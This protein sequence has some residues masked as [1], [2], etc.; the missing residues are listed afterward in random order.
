M[1]KKV[2]VPVGGEIVEGEEVEF[3]PLEENWNKY[4]VEDGT[5]IKFKAVISRIVRTQKY[6]QITGDPIYYVVSSNVIDALV[7]ENLKKEIK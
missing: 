4:Q 2:R 3:K 6:N 5:I 1:N 7:P